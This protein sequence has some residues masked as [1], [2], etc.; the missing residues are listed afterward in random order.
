MNTMTPEL[1]RFL[2]LHEQIEYAELTAAVQKAKAAQEAGQ[3]DYTDS[4]VVVKKR[5][6]ELAHSPHNV[7]TAKEFL[8]FVNRTQ[9]EMWSEVEAFF[10]LY[11]RYLAKRKNIAI[12]DH[13]SGHGPA[14]NA[15]A[16]PYSTRSVVDT[17]FAKAE[18]NSK[19]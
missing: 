7:L 2:P 3:T 8:S 9:P 11:D 12:P 6:D 16:N 4:A 14:T 1:L 19:K 15:S 5:I 10:K 17:V 18:R 13:W